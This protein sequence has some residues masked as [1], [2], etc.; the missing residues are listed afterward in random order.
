MSL[1]EALTASEAQDRVSH[2]SDIVIVPYSSYMEPDGNVRLSIFSEMT[3]AAAAT[4]YETAGTEHTRI[5]AVGEQTYGPGYPSTTELMYA[6]LQRHGIAARAFPRQHPEDANATPQQI[7]WLKQEFGADWQS[8]A[9][10]LVGHEHHWARIRRL[11]RLFRLP[12]DFVD[13]AA[14]LEKAGKLTPAYA[15]AAAAYQSEGQDYERDVT[16]LTRFI[17]PLGAGPATA[18]FRTLVRART[19]TVVDVV[20]DG[21]DGKLRLY[22]TTVREHLRSLAHEGRAA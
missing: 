16:R 11:C 19:P 5:V 12:A 1:P 22:A 20:R 17:S 6:Y 10:V 4:L 9:P 18:M 14:I 2:G 15:E 21:S 8:R 7:E 13:A 3:T